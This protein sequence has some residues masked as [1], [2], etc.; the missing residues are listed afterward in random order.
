MRKIVGAAFQSIDGVM[1]APGG[2]SEDPTGGFAFGGW[3]AAYMGSP[4]SNAIEPF[5]KPPFALLL[6]RR[7]Y[8][9]FAAYWPYAKG[10]D[11]EIGRAFDEA[12]KFVLTHRDEP[13]AWENSHRVPDMAA[14]RDIKDGDGPD[15]RIWGSSTLYPALI[16]AGLLDEVTLFTYPLVLGNGKR[17][18]EP[19][20][21]AKAMRCVAQQA[22]PDGVSVATFRPVGEVKPG[23]V[24]APANNERE[25]SR[26]EAIAEGRW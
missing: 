22:Y 15:L 13:L 10:E 24:S 17:V 21:P 14:L 16:Q 2:E 26:Q 20:T 18:F 25:A 12:E 7:T 6:G 9:I 1:Q 23:N 19:G 3:Q 8:D 4:A 11:V 5:L